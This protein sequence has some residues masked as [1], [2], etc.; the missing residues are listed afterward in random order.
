MTKT[1][2]MSIGIVPL[3]ALLGSCKFGPPDSMLAERAFKQAG[4]VLKAQPPE[5]R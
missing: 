4:D 5:G 2:A 1:L 3:A